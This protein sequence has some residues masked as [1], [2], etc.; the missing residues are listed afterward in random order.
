ML[1]QHL[2]GNGD[3]LAFAYNTEEVING[4][5]WGAHKK[6]DIPPVGPTITGSSTTATPL[7]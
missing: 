2:T 6:G 4:V 3:V 1:G 5:G 7:T